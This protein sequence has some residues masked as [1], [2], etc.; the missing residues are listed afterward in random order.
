[1]QRSEIRHRETGTNGG[2]RFAP[3]AL[4]LLVRPL[5]AM[6]G[7]SG[8]EFTY[9]VI[10]NCVKRL[11]IIAVAVVSI[12]DICRL[13]SKASSLLVFFYGNAEH[14]FVRGQRATRKIIGIL[15]LNF[16]SGAVF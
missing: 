14:K 8:V 4:R 12:S 1:M 10:S 2:I 15:E 3:S 16:D 5:Q 11:F 6:G 13:Q 7:Y 9:T